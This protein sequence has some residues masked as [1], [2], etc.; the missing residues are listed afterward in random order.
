MKELN[1]TIY[2][3]IGFYF[4]NIDNLYNFGFW[5]WVWK[6]KINKRISALGYI[7]QALFF[8]KN[9]LVQKLRSMWIKGLHELPLGKINILWMKRRTK[10]HKDTDNF[11]L[12]TV[13]HNKKTKSPQIW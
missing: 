11:P 13:W 4:I 5:N 8:L 10:T 1:F 3:L 7:S 12:I 2:K 6:P 9:V